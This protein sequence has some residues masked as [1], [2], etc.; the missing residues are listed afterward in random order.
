MNLRSQAK[1]PH[2]RLREWTSQ[3]EG[4][5]PRP[6]DLKSQV[7]GPHPSQE[8]EYTKLK[9]LESELVA[10]IKEWQDVFA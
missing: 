9:D 3:V 7:K 8:G 1:E 10:L 2:P 4:P 6:R 5:H